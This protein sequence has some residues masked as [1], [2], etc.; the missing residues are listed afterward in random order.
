MSSHL[1]GFRFLT[2][3][4]KVG[5]RQHF[6]KLVPEISFSE[7]LTL[8]NRAPVA[9]TEPHSVN[10]HTT[11]H[12]L[13]TNHLSWLCQYSKPVYT[14]SAESARADQ[15]SPKKGFSNLSIHCAKEWFSCMKI[16]YFDHTHLLYTLYGPL[17][18][19]RGPLLLPK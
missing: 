1:S 5:P 6:G 18:F 11:L 15:S 10:K 2:Y 7:I 13:S 17:S 9:R 8:Y 14:A 4:G 16:K 3:K 12:L 19:S